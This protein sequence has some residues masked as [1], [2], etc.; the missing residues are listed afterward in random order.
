MY[1]TFSFKKKLLATLVASSAL[2]LSHVAF[3][4]EVEEVVVTGIRA[5]LTAAM[6]IKR[7]AAG[8]VDAI[9]AEDI[10]K[11]PDTNLAESLQRITGVS[12]NRAD[13]EGAKIT[14]RGIGQELNMVTLNGRSMPAVSNGGV[15]QPGTRAFD[16][17][18][19][20]SEGVNGVEVYKTGRASNT[21]GGL[22]ATVNIKTLKPLDGD[23]ETKASFG[24]KVLTDE[25]VRNGR[26]DKYTPEVS[27]LYSWA[28][29]EKT[30]GVS[31]IGSFQKRNSVNS[32]SF[33]N[34][35][36]QKTAGDPT[37]DDKKIDAKTGLPLQLTTDGTLPYW[38]AASGDQTNGDIA[39]SSKVS[40]INAPKKGEMYNMPT[41][42]R[43]Q[44]SNNERVRENAQLTF[45]FRPIEN[46]TAT[47]D[48]TYS[49]ND[50][51]QDRAQQTNWFNISNISNVQFNNAS[52]KSPL[53]YQE[54]YY[55]KN[56]K[57][58]AFAQY[59]F[60]GNT[61]NDS[62]G[63]NLAY[64]A[65]DSLK[66]GLD[67]HNSQA[68]NTAT[69]NE[70]SVMA[71]QTVTEYADFSNDLPVLGGTF[72]DNSKASGRKG[73]NVVNM[74]G[75]P[76]LDAD[77]KQIVDKDGKPVYKEW[78]PVTSAGPI[79]QNGNG[80]G[81]LDAG[82]ISGAIGTF[83]YSHQK[84]DIK[85]LR[86]FGS[87][88]LGAVGPL[89]KATINFGVDSREDTNL[90]ANGQN[91]IG[92][93]NW[94]GVDPSRFEDSYF[95]T[96][97]FADA[98]P[99]YKDT[100]GNA[101]FQHTAFIARTA[102]L[103]ERVEFENAKGT[104]PQN[105]YG[106]VNG[107][108][109]FDGQL[110]LNRTITEEVT[111]AFTEFATSFEIGG[112]ASNVLA[113]LRFESTDI[114]ASSLVNKP[115]SLEWESDN[116][117]KVNRDSAK[118]AARS[119]G[120][121]TNV[122]PSIDFDISPTDD[123]KTR[124]SY[125]KT[126]GRPGYGDMRPD[127]GINS[128]YLKTANR[129]NANLAAMTSD[130]ID[131]S[132]EWYYSES[133]YVSAGYFMKKV[134]GFIGTA[135]SNEA[136]YGLRDIRT[137][138]RFAKF[139]ADN[140]SQAKDE[141]AQHTAMLVSEEKDPKDPSTSAFAD[142]KDPL[143]LWAMNAPVNDKS[144]TIDGIELGVQH[145]FG[146]SGFGVTANFTAVDAGVKFDVNKAG[147]QFA[148]V[149]LS[150]TAN[151][152]AFYDKNDWQARIAYNWRDSFLDNRTA[153]GSNEPSFTTAYGQVDFTVGY[154]VTEQVTV[155]AEG[156]NLLGANSR[157]YGRNTDQMISLEDL[158]ARYAVGVRAT[159]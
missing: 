67:Y 140:P 32:Y 64:E 17:S 26:G 146:E 69:L 61:Q 45:Q 62:V 65:T 7:E 93:G 25:T 29:E 40:Y 125:S 134:D 3:A 28:N 76:N 155:T 80:N 31:L 156:L 143:L 150:N 36:Q 88:D 145:M 49:Q 100:T 54:Q 27:G 119:T 51:V 89:S 86:L 138:P 55:D 71:I 115:V 123:V 131:L 12:I 68:A 1:K 147:G 42:L 30:L 158:G 59:D 22:G 33:V 109:K 20:A 77:K 101:N 132:V 133:S 154:K 18:N 10:G 70:A 15:G 97:D 130:N 72:K 126:L 79:Y 90:T 148:M 94:D 13:G 124:L 50:L 105:F 6:D 21:T 5:S 117:W 136:A 58:S 110:N 149:G 157:T 75:L 92:M 104:D 139:V 87:Y 2:G 48:Y 53:V 152:I 35:W 153:G 102:D 84:T 9:S 81:V 41:D 137:G 99:D 19:I 120:S 57:D 4:E 37:F 95:T 43:Y 16:F 98:F 108:A 103:Y 128:I 24:G 82:D 11:M 14:A 23:A 52:V 142:D 107:K 113:G 141:V 127:V 8:V 96:H 56:N 116:D 122:L 85:Q 78:Y 44:L 118:T 46:L 74:V 129:G 135:V 63:F 47:L 144:T 38:V 39:P 159:F 151:L 83:D 66:F 121:Y 91:R 73:P 112:M 106:F 114:T 60:A 111:A 34:A